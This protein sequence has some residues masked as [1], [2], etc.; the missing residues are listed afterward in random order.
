[1]FILS[2]VSWFKFTTIITLTRESRLHS[3]LRN[4]HGITSIWPRL[5]M[6]D[7]SV[8]GSI[9]V[10]CALTGLQRAAAGY[11]HIYLSQTA[12]AD[13]SLSPFIRCTISR[14]E[15]QWTIYVEEEQKRNEFK[16]TYL[17]M[18]QR[19]VQSSYAATAGWDLDETNN[20][21]IVQDWMMCNANSTKKWLDKT[22]H[23]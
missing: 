1:M 20:Y 18:S 23:W 22:R 15:L 11:F 6:Y 13:A 17:L 4:T 5:W 8:S 2:H 3:T 9:C 7:S 19:S 14:D 21:R 10:C 12:V 16:T